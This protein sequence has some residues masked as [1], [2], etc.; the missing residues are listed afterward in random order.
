MGGHRIEQLLQTFVDALQ[1]EKGYSPHTARAYRNDLQGFFRFAAAW[2]D[3]R[4]LGTDD[5]DAA[6][7]VLQ[8]PDPLLLRAYLAALHKENRKSTIARKLSA[9]RSFYRHLVKH[10]VTACNPTDQVL[11]PK[12]DHPLPK[13]LSVDDVFRLLDAIR[14]D[15]PGGL[16]D[17]A[18]FETLYSCG[19][20]V[21]EV[22]GLDLED[23]DFEAGML[24]VLGKGAKER[25]V[26]IGRKALDAV[27]AYRQRLAVEK[28]TTEGR[29]GPL[30]L[31]KF[32]KRLSTRSIARI[33][34]KLVEQCSLII[35]IS[36]HVLRHTFATHM[37]DAGADLR[38][39]QELLGHRSL[40]TTQKYTHVSIDRLMETYDRAH[41]RK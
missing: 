16:R 40:S 4:G 32:G 33:L 10:G 3:D 25:I 19:L 24:R 31:N 9:L 17:R 35:P 6:E 1:A 22:A 8:E 14:T 29:Q 5:R 21:S 39:V 30:F 41:P 13:Y 28:G 26:P 20:R 37:L 18:I 15:S 23:I 11:T 12:Q 38:A 2:T 27:K 36:P 7:A 34:N